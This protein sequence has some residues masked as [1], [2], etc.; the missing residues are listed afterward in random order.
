M[1]CVTMFVIGYMTMKVSLQT[2]DLPTGEIACLIL[3]LCVLI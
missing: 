2:V 3:F 1:K